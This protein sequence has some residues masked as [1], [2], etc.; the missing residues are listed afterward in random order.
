M[1]NGN[2]VGPAPG[3]R[4]SDEENAQNSQTDNITEPELCKKGINAI[5]P[6]F[7]R[8]KF[9]DPQL[10]LLY[11]AYVR[12]EKR[13]SLRMLLGYAF[14]FNFTAVC[15]ISYSLAVSNEINIKEI[16]LTAVMTI[17]LVRVLTKYLFHTL[18]SFTVK[19]CAILT[20]ITWFLLCVDI[21]LYIGLRNISISPED[22]GEWCLVL[23]YLTFVVMPLQFR[24]NIL[25]STVFYLVIIIEGSVIAKFQNFQIYY[26]GNQVRILEMSRSRSF[27]R[28]LDRERSG[29]RCAFKEFDWPVYRNGSKRQAGK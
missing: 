11:Q 1:K 17:S 9:A 18:R 2:K 22:G 14:V 7:L 8:G 15:L 5:L 12:R 29:R 21:C 19:V 24:W 13:D 6:N 4:G 27:W 3:T 10:E 20:V 26:I 16:I 23:I 28:C 25:G